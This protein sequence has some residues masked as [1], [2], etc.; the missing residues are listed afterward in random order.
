MATLNGTVK[1]FN[2]AKGYGFLLQDPPADDAKGD[3]FI[4]HT[5]INMPGYRTLL[6]GQK[7]TFEMA[8]LAKGG[9]QA[10]NVV[11]VKTDAN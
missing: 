4:H 2:A 6:E 1:W 11:P 8:T 5:N 9:L 3:I 7:V 10:T